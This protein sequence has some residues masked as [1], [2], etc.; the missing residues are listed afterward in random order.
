MQSNLCQN[1][2]SFI[3]QWP[4]YP[5]ELFPYLLF[6]R[7]LYLLQYNL[8]KAKKMGEKISKNFE[9]YQSLEHMSYVLNVIGV[10]LIIIGIIL[11]ITMGYIITLPDVVWFDA[12]I[13]G[14]VFVIIVYC[15]YLYLRIS[16][17]VTGKS[18]A[19]W[20]MAAFLIVLINF[21]LIGNFSTFHMWL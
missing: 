1:Y 9:I 15:L 20:N 4:F 2:C 6:F 10:P 7:F 12:K 13:I 14:S 18:L 17:G 3:L 8:L 19:M 21:F 16:K 5:M 11:G